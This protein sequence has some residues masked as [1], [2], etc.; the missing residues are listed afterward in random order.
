MSNPVTQTRVV[1]AT[2][3][4]P[5]ACCAVLEGGIG[6]VRFP[7]SKLLGVTW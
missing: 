6:V 7:E 3:P 4:S 2:W 1:V 5:G